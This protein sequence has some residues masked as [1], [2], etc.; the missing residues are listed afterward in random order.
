MKTIL[1]IALTLIA[2]IAPAAAQ[3]VP[4]APAPRT[5]TVRLHTEVGDIDIALEVERAP[6]TAGNFLRYVD[7]KRLD[8][9]S[10]YRAVGDREKLSY[11]FIQ[12]GAQN[13]P[14]RTLPP[15]AHEPTTNTGLSHGEGSISMARYAPGSATGDFFITLGD[16]KS[17]DA[18]PALP[19]DNAGFAAFGHVVAGMD[20]VKGILGAPLSPTLG[21]GVMKGQML[22]PQIRIVTARL[23][24]R[25]LL[26]SAN[27]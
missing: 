23:L 27:F 18:N 6:V 8:G 14:K 22:A 9:T 4:D 17:M 10:F 11:G 12:G 25:R 20:V 24:P 15:I 7:Q 5:V 1:L 13:D 2:S 19:G 26:P 3:S 21:E 16:M